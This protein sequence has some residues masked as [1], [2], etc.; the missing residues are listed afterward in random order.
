MERKTE[1][2]ELN[3]DLVRFLKRA[4]FYKKI[5]NRHSLLT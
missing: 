4:Q 1:K 3:L 5:M 2:Q